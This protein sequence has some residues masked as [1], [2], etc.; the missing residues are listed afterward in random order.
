MRVVFL[1]SADFGL[2]A[3]Q[4]LPKEGH[5][6]VGVVSTPDR[7]SGRG[8]KPTPSAVVQHCRQTGLSPIWTPEKLDTESFLEGLRA[9]GADLFVVAAFRI[10]PEM[11]FS[12]PRLG[13]VN[14][15]AS[16]LPKYRGPAPIQRA[17]E[18]GESETGVT[19]FLIDRGIDTGRVLLQKRIP[20]GSSE[21]TPELYA[22]LSQLGADAVVEA[23]AGLAQGTLEPFRQDDVQATRAPKLSKEEARI[24]WEEPAVRLYNRVRAFKPFPGTYALRDGKRLGVEWA[25]VVDTHGHGEPGT[26][27][28]VSASGFEV[29]CG[30]G[31]LRVTEVKPEGRK[32]MSASAYLRGTPLASGT[33]LS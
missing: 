31:R 25:E 5:D 3:L 30:E 23:A 7:P 17:I 27:T 19:V 12:L 11:V 1:G 33:E 15:H 9:V 13:T 18:N 14:I 8:L 10:L 2:P 16:L 4:R 32:A 24:R 21:T 20:I 22:R 6:I 28:A 26:V 29:Q